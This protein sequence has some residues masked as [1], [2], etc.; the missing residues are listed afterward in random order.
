MFYIIELNDFYFIATSE[1]VEVV[2][3]IT[4]LIAFR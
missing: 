4:Y 2:E 3:V 1:G